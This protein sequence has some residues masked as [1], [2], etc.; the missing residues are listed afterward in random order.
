[1]LEIMRSCWVQMGRIWLV[2]SWIFLSKGQL[3]D[4]ATSFEHIS[5]ISYYCVQKRLILKPGRELW[6]CTGF[7]LSEFSCTAISKH[8][9]LSWDYYSFWLLDSSGVWKRNAAA[10]QTFPLVSQ[11]QVQIC[12]AILCVCWSQEHC[13]WTATL[14]L[15]REPSGP[16]Y[17]RGWDKPPD[18]T[19]PNRMLCHPVSFPAAH[20][21]QV[22][23]NPSP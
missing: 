18:P 17:S 21:P 1:M 7:G 10:L 12:Y 4:S 19:P 20:S 3:Q 9:S 5:E 11:A 22:T 13:F 2:F 16:K 23:T 15:S 14:W 8:P 6:H